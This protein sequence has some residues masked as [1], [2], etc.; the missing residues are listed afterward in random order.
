MDFLPQRGRIRFVLVSPSHPGNI[1]SAAR[2]IKTMGFN[3]LYVVS[4]RHP[5]YRTDLD[6]IAFSTHAVDVL[7]NSV[8][9]ETLLEA[10]KDVSFACALSGYDREFG[11]PLADLQTSC[12]M[13]K[14]RLEEN[15]QEEIAFVFG[16]ERSGLTN[17]E[18][19]LCQLCTAI[20][21][22]PECDSLNLAQAVQVTAYQAQ[23]TL[24]GRALD[25]H[26]N[27]FE[28][29]P[30]AS[31]EAIEGLY[32]H[33]EAAMIA[34]GALNPERPKLKRILSR[35]GLSAPDV[36]ML[37]GICAAIICPR[38]ERSGRKTNKDGQ[39]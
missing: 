1:G 37:R 10:L 39:Q 6:A 18:M 26:A 28:G 8:C 25:A 30:P 33:L 12:E 7:Q 2:A 31:V 35:S 24:R 11:P 27:R 14:A 3:R 13:V 5:E 23:Q 36:D 34:C 21:A 16:T 19:M 20:P 29:E 4:P 32:E 38:A 17:E 15:P 9:T 22:N